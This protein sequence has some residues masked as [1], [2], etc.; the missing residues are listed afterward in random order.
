MSS[1]T[2]SR[3][4]SADFAVRMDFPSRQSLSIGTVSMNL[5][6]SL[7]SSIAEGDG[8][9]VGAVLGFGGAEGAAFA[10]GG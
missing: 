6:T 8:A 4:A 9:T 7:M 1:R 5:L 10:K 3:M 2:H